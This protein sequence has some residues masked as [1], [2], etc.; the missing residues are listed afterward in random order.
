[1]K[2]HKDL[3]PAEEQVYRQ[4]AR[5]NYK[6]SEGTDHSWHPVVLDEC[7]KMYEEHL[8][9]KE[10]QVDVVIK[11]IDLDLLREQ[12]RHLIAIQSEFTIFPEQDDAIDGVLSLIDAIQDYAVDVLGKDKKRVYSFKKE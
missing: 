9:A 8:E 3:N 2:L 10:K 12:K 6:V 7:Q 1:M 4:W 5:D 11:N